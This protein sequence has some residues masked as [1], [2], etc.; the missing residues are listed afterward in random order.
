MQINWHAINTA[1]YINK[2]AYKPTQDVL[3][4]FKFLA[5]KNSANSIIKTYTYICLIISLLL[6]HQVN[7]FPN[8]N[9]LGMLKS[10]YK[11]YLK[12]AV[13]NPNFYSF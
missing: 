7:A 8:N 13:S 9:T 5:A 1:L 11:Y 3:N 10:K 4:K 6:F 2:L 12:S